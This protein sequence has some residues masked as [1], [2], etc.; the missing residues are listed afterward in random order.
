M[1]S[2]RVATILWFYG[3]LPQPVLS[4]GHSVCNYLFCSL[5]LDPLHLSSWAHRLWKGYRIKAT[6]DPHSKPTS[7]DA[8]VEYY[9]FGG[10]RSEVVEHRARFQKRRCTWRRWRRMHHCGGAY[11]LAP[12]VLSN[13]HPVA[14]SRTVHYILHLQ[15]LA[16]HD[17]HLIISCP[18]GS[19]IGM[20]FITHHFQ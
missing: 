14:T 15:Y 5:S 9:L 8:S 20:S 7:V 6:L 13:F 4:Q 10:C 12:R 1:R 19:I 3:R 11:C 2:S 18:S 17:L 16:S